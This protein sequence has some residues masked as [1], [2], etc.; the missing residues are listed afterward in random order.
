VVLGPADSVEISVAAPMC[1]C[2]VAFGV[3]FDTK[4]EEGQEVNENYK[5]GSFVICASEQ[6][7]TG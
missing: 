5:T 1:Y 3:K 7:I 2:C 6:T 4:R